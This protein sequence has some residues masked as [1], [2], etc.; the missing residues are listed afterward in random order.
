MSDRE[1]FV[2]SVKRNK[3]TLIAVMLLPVLGMV[4]AIILILWKSPQSAL[5]TIPIIVVLMIIHGLL[6]RWVLGKVDEIL[7]LLRNSESQNNE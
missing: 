3:K 6:V 5:V 1:I 7:D 2:E 4:I